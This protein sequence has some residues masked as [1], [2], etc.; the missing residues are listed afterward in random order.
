MANPAP[1][2]HTEGQ[3]E[4]AR[5]EMFRD[6]CPK[7]LQPGNPYRVGNDYGKA[8]AQYPQMLFRADRIPPGLPGAGKFGVSASEPKRYGFRDDDD[9]NHARQEAT[10]FTESCNFVVHSEDQHLK[11]RGQ[12][13]RD[14]PAEALELAESGRLERGDIAHAQD[15][16]DRNMSEKA[17]AEKAEFQ[18][19]NF[20][21]QPEIKEKPV[22]RR[23]K[24]ESKAKGA[25]A[26]AA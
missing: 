5:F 14:S 8:G 10:R 13:W 11:M 1:V 23:V 3:K 6:D 22:T 25:K 4:A 16:A 26:A 17:L 18:A 12:G 15:Y 21:H 24:K 2:H 7:G 20:G 9:W 19:G